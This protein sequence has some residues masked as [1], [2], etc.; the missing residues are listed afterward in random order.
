MKVGKLQ[1]QK[2][3]YNPRTTHTTDEPITSA[4]E[5]KILDQYYTK[6]IMLS[7][8]FRSVHFL[9]PICYMLCYSSLV[10]SSLDSSIFDSL[11]VSI[12]Y[13]WLSV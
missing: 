5:P 11:A 2:N 8:A 7:L 12:T 10:I 1:R 9:F 3:H 6:H 13:P 4:L